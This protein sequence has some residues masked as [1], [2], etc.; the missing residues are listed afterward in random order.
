[1]YYANIYTF[2]TRVFAIY[3]TFYARDLLQSY[4][5]SQNLAT[6]LLDIAHWLC[7]SVIWVRR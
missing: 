5:F 2:Y 6:P 4:T 3:Y 1:M 7:F